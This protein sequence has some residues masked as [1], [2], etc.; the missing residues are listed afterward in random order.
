MRRPTTDGKS[1]T[2]VRAALYT[3]GAFHTL[4]PKLLALR[5]RTGSAR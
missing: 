1:L 2:A 3:A 5:A 4:T